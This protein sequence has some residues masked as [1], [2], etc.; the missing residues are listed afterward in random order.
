MEGQ[1]EH[2]NGVGV[3]RVPTQGSNLVRGVLTML[4]G[5]WDVS[6]G[7]VRAIQQSRVQQ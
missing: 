5:P 1:P 2:P 3:R 6:I 4:E 7:K